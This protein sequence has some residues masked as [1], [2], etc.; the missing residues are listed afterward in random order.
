MAHDFQAI[1][2]ISL[3]ANLSIYY[4]LYLKLSKLNIVRILGVALFG[5]IAN[6]L[7]P[8]DLNRANP[9]SLLDTSTLMFNMF[10]K[11]YGMSFLDH[12]KQSV[13]V[14]SVSC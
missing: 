7:F 10:E 11:H 5:V 2:F 4:F 8:H 9:T 14:N 12:L 3:R 1:V 6:Q 13:L